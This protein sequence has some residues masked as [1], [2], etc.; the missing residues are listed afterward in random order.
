MAT[1][2][3]RIEELRQ[4]AEVMA[5]AAE[6]E[7]TFTE[8]VEAF[9][10][11]DASR[12]QDI[13][14]RLG[15]LEHCR[16]V[17]QY[18]CSKHVVYVCQLLAGEGGDSDK[19]SIEEWR[20]FAQLT[21]R[22][23]S[24]DDLLRTLVNAVEDGD[25]KTFQALVAKLDAS[26]F[27]HQLCHWVLVLRCGWVCRQMCP[28]PPLITH[29]G[30]IQTSQIAPNGYA[31]GPSSPPG[32]T[33]SD[34][35]SP[36]GVGD[37]PYGGSTNVKG[38]FNTAGATEYKVEFTPA[39]G[40]APTAITPAIT[41]TRFNPLWP[42]PGEPLTVNYVRAPVGDWY[43]I[44]EMGLLGADY[45]TEW[46]TTVVADGEFD[47]QLT[48][49]SLAERSS[50]RVRVVVDNTSPSGPGPGGS[51]IMTIRQGDHELDCCETV[52]EKNGPLTIH[53]EGEDLNFSSMSVSLYGGCSFGLSIF[54]KTYDG[55]LADRGAPAPGID[56][57]WDPW[58]LDIEKCCYVIFFRIYDRAII[59][60]AYSSGNPVAETWRS[61]T[62]A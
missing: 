49:R 29:V 22:I 57:P 44:A 32:P 17:C 12:F 54:S 13:L 37:H 8:L 1:D 3:E 5:K 38:V 18:L 23:A 61:I 50:P 40:G 60:N 42:A 51:P 24:D 6:D 41:D 35:K 46:N 10:G 39:G 11:L 21:A 53:V 14:G 25:A 52:E 28:P 4:S 34:V 9:R 20:A 16:I 55:D 30:L 36:G 48:V 45:L 19:L 62:I 47:L 31:A 27:A 43:T 58:A 33:S 59:G 7:G 2:E 26:R 15:L 56:I